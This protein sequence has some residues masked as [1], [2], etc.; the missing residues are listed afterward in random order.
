MMGSAEEQEARRRETKEWPLGGAWF[1]VTVQMESVSRDISRV[2]QN[3]FK[4]K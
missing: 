1:D 4:G 2:F 3:R